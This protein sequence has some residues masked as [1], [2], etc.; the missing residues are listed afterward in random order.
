[1]LDY[2]MKACAPHVTGKEKWPGYWN[3]ETDESAQSSATESD[4]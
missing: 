1:M 4:S 2:G 3:V